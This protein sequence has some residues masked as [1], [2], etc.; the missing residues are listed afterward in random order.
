MQTAAAAR[1][2]P[3]QFGSRSETGIQGIV[4]PRV[5]AWTPAVLQGY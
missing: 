1:L 5:G 3:D 2:D 4:K